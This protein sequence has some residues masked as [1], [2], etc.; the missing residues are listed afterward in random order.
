MGAAYRRLRGRDGLGLGDAKLLA[1]AGA[2]TGWQD[3][4]AIIVG[5][6]LL[7]IGIALLERMRGNPISAT[8]RIPLGT[9]MAPFIFLAA[10]GIWP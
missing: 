10:I 2:W 7:G 6:A 5:A 8:T 4:G 3:L 9:C 1:L